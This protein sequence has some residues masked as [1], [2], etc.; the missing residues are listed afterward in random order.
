[1]NGIAAAGGCVQAGPGG[2]A[3]EVVGDLAAPFDVAAAMLNAATTTPTSGRQRRRRRRVVAPPARFSQP[4]RS[5][6]DGC[7]E[8]AGQHE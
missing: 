2:R 1:M 6:Q 7:L 5:R 8:R 4:R 3:T